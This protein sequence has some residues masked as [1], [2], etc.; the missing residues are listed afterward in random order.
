MYVVPF[1]G[2]VRRVLVRSGQSVLKGDALVQIEAMKMVHTIRAPEDG[3]VWSVHVREGDSIVPGGRFAD[4]VPRKD[5]PAA[6]LMRVV[7]SRVAS[8]VNDKAVE[9]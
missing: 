9:R 3:R 7:P 4:L 5:I 8:R 2:T 1:P 6:G